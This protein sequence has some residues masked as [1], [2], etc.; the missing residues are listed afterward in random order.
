ML[1]TAEP[2]FD[3]GLTLHRAGRLLEAART[4][5]AVIAA[6][7]R[8]APALLY[9]G[10]LRLQQ[11]RAEEAESLLRRS[12]A[13]EPSAAAQANLGAALLALGRIDDA[14]AAHT[15]ATE[16]EP[17]LADFWY[18][19]GNAL[20]DAGRH[21][22]ALA[23]FERM[24]DLSPDQPEGAYGVGAALQALRRFGK[25]VAAYDQ[26]LALDPGF[27][28]ALY[29]KATCLQFGGRHEAAIS[30][31]EQVLAILP[32][33]GD[34]HHAIAISLLDQDLGPRA[35]EH[36]DRA[37]QA[38]PASDERHYRRGDAL[39][40]LDR[41]KDAE[42][43]YRKASELAPKRVEAILGLA[44]AMEAQAVDAEVLPLYEQAR[45]LEPENAVV[46]C[47]LASALLP[48][49][50]HEEAMALLD[51]AKALR[52]NLPM[53][54]GGLGHAREQMGDMEGAQDAFREALRLAPRRPGFYAGLFNA[55]KVAA[56]DPLIEALE[57]LATDGRTLRRQ[58]QIARLF[59]LAKAYDDIGD[60]A[61]AFDCLLEGNAMKRATTN[62][63]ESKDIAAHRRIQ[64]R[65]SGPVIRA[66]AGRGDPTEVPIFV[67]GMPRSGSTLVE[68]ILASHPMV[69]PGGERKDFGKALRR[70]WN[71]QR[72][73][74]TSDMANAEQ[75]RKLARLYLE[76]LPPL[77]PGK[78]RITD[79]MPGNYLTAGLIH[80]AMPNARIIHTRRDPVDTCL[81][82]F[83]KL[84]GDKLDW[85]Y[86][87]GELGPFY[88]RYQDMMEHWEDVLPP[89]SILDVQYEDVV[90]D[91]E[92][93]ARRLLDFCGLPWD[94][95]CLS[96]HKTKRAVRTASVAQVREPIYRRSVGK[97]RPDEAVLRPLLDGLASQVP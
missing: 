84:F 50:R 27:A 7:P 75:L 35:L 28:E 96:F 40:L 67:L 20:R 33:D 17:G 11:G 44:S 2:D 15:A 93:Q 95:A 92:G 76:Q 45:A 87:L 23:A 49:D 71:R 73:Q 36:L 47:A 3:T 34:T 74:S 29:G 83:S 13:Q 37:I 48:L 55:G 79:K 77:P 16:A 41:H 85:T 64:T 61:R 42:A 60:K 1:L 59:A 94:E 31:F 63:D 24:A 32:N 8:H 4:Y 5:A 82:C 65:L 90:D 81:S 21:E 43:A 10:V 62:Y 26:A 66:G 6:E 25:A 56:G 54:W 53:V 52:P 72:G 14:I 57:N 12:V 58:E 51:E 88:R 46:L 70:T 91:L 18:G 97:W 78:T 9:L 86:D 19:L 80:T 68:Q 39:M 22:D 69:L 89:G 38:D 30:L